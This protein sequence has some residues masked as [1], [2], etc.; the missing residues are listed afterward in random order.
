MGLISRAPGLGTGLYFAVMGLAA[1]YLTYAAVQ[2][3]YGLFRR[4]E[5]EARISGLEAEL[6]ELD[7]SAERL[8]ALTLRL[9]D[10]YLDLDLLDE[11]ARD[12]LGYVSAGEIVLR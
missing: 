5:V 11:R 8:G 3:S 1:M 4:I 10:D 7:R 9:S 2:G 12:V 6:A